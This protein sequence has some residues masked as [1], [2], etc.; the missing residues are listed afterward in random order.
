MLCTEASDQLRIADRGLRK[1][2][3]RAIGVS[4]P[5]S[6]VPGRDGRQETR[7]WRKIGKEGV[8]GDGQRKAVYVAGKGDGIRPDPIA[9][10]GCRPV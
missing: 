2:R 8:I 10:P 1:E 9:R 7:A 5:Q 6:G 4:G 3:R